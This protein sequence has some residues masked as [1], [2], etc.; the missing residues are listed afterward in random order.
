MVALVSSFHLITSHGNQPRTQ[1]CCSLLLPCL[2][3]ATR[4]VSP[5]TRVVLSATRVV[6]P[7]TKVVLFA[8]RVVSPATRVVPEVLLG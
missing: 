6:S 3:A 2:H 1:A 8:T 5:A 7:A 4:V